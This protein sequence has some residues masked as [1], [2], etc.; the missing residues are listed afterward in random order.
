LAHTVL[1]P[2]ANTIENANT[3]MTIV[4]LRV[5]MLDLLWVNGFRLESAGRP[6]NSRISKNYSF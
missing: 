6:A 1:I 2:A 3:T 5:F 4:F